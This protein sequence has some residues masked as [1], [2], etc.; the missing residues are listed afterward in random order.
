M[1]KFFGTDGCAVWGAVILIG[2]GFIALA[3][4]QRWFT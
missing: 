2:A 3:V 4:W 1:K